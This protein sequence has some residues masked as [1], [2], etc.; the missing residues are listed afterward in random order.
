[1]LCK[2][3]KPRLAKILVHNGQG[4]EATMLIHHAEQHLGAA[5]NVRDRPSQPA[6]APAMRV[7]GRGESD[8]PLACLRTIAAFRPGALYAGRDRQATRSEVSGGGGLCG[9]T[10]DD[11]SLVSSSDRSQ[12]RRL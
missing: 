2:R 12:V 4:F 7:P 5:A 3:L 6:P 11:P 10:G 9:Q 8:S 1:M